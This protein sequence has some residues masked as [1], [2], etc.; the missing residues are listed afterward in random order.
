VCVRTGFRSLRSASLRLGLCF[1]VGKV[2]GAPK[3]E[4]AIR[5]SSGGLAP[6]KAVIT[7]PALLGSICVLGGELM[8]QDR[9]FEDEPFQILRNWRNRFGPRAGRRERR[10]F[11]AKRDKDVKAIVMT[12]WGR[13]TCAGN[14]SRMA[15]G[16][17]SARQS[18]VLD[19]MCETV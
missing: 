15:P 11:H 12:S 8:I 18:R 9:V 10:T 16:L 7:F 17:S 2:R 19:D 14:G 13:K 3:E 1:E 4:R 5:H 6:R